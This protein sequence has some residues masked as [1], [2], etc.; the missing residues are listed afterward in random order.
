M[1]ASLLT[2]VTLCFFFGA[3]GFT[4]PIAGLVAYYPFSGNAD[5]V[6]GHGLN[7]TVLGATLTTDRFGTPNAAYYFG[8]DTQRIVVPKS[9]AFNLDSITM[10]AWV[11]YDT[12]S[13]TNNPRIIGA[14]YDSWDMYLNGLSSPRQVGTGF[15]GS[16]IFMGVHTIDAGSWHFLSVTESTD[17]VHIYIDG[18]RDT[19]FQKSF[20]L[21]YPLYGVVI[22]ARPD[23]FQ[24]DRYQG[25]IDE[26]RIYNRPLT[27]SEILELSILPP[28]YD[29]DGVP[30]SI[31]NCPHTYNPDQAD[32]DHDGIGDACDNCPHT[33]NPDQADWNHDGIGD[34]CTPTSTGS[35]VTVQPSQNTT[36][37]FPTVSQGGTTGTIESVSG[38]TPPDNYGV[39][40]LGHPKYYQI[41]TTATYQGQVEVCITYNDSDVVGSEMDLRLMH[42]NGTTWEDITNSRDTVTHT[43]CGYTSSLSPFALVQHCCLGKRG[44]LNLL[45][46]VDLADLTAL[47]SYL[48]GG[49]YHLPCVDAANLNGVGTVDL[50]DLSALV[51]YLTGGG[52]VL[53]NCP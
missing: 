40:P 8:G 49:G 53:P 23:N 26:V 46:V 6:S 12:G 21:P 33:Y 36:V 47:V 31:D 13:G 38:P 5:D 4:Q 3:S 15:G 16:N 7:G 44:N 22:G 29:N 9:S 18:I 43:I 45:G 1:R 11:S 19:G 25:K 48:T 42:F 10:C 17:S 50:G 39:V 24:A 27:D 2:A 32:S 41:S 51:S 30:D 35:S 34:A 52:F 14:G 37:T 28:D 20:A